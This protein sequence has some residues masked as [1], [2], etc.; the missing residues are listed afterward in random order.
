MFHY[1]QEKK[2]YMNF[3]NFRD[4]EMFD[5]KSKIFLKQF[6]LNA[7]RKFSGSQNI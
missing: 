2:N 4:P 3:E 6:Y 5:K 1:N 7:L